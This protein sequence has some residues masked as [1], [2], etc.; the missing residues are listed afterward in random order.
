MLLVRT[1]KGRVVYEMKRKCAKL[2]VLPGCSARWGL[3][4]TENDQYGLRAR[5]AFDEHFTNNR[6]LVT[7]NGMYLMLQLREYRYIIDM[8]VNLKTNSIQF[9]EPKEIVPKEGKFTAP[10]P[11]EYP[12]IVD[13]ITQIRLDQDINDHLLSCF[14]VSGEGIL[15][16]LTSRSL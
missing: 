6:A 13:G 10:N 1:D 14:A 7:S 11:S 2:D 3:P 12:L 9:L 15:K 8:I 4:V 5:T 16:K